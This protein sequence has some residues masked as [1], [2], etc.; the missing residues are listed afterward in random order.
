MPNIEEVKT[1]IN[2][3]IVEKLSVNEELIKPEA[4][5]INDLGADSLDIVQFVMDLEEEFDVEI[6]DEDSEKLST[7][8]DVYKYVEEKLK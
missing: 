7:V 8:G 2:N 6:S 5:F 3:L 1:T 4:N